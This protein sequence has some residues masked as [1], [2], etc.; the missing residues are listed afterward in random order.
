MTLVPVEALALVSAG[1]VCGI[2]IGFG[3]VLSAIRKL[4]ARTWSSRAETAWILA[5]VT[6]MVFITL[7]PVFLIS[8]MVFG[9]DPGGPLFWPRM[10]FFVLGI[11]VGAA[12]AFGSAFLVNRGY[13][14]VVGSDA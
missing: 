13:C 2:S 11:L 14:T 6:G 3:F 8:Y 12:F 1:F 7:A 9:N 10:L 4:F 5:M